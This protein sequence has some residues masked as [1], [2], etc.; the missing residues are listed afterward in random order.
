MDVLCTGAA[1]FIGSHTVDL[2]V[3]RGHRV[4]ALDSLDP[5]VHG[6]NATPKNLQGHLDRGAIEFIMGDVRDR[7]LMERLVQRADAVLHLAA[8]V[9]IGQ[10]MYMP[11]HYADVNVGGTALLLE[12]LTD[13]A[14]RRVQRLVVASSMSLYGEGQG[15]CPT[16]GPVVPADRTDENLARGRFELF[17]GRCGAQVEPIATPEDKPL[18]CTSIYAITKK[19]QEEM[20]VVFGR[21]YGLPVVALRY[22]NVYGPRQ[23]LNNPYTGVA[24]IFL[25]RLMNGHSP[26]VFEDGG[27]SRDFISVRDIARANVLSLESTGTGQAIYN[28]GTG[29]NTSVLGVAEI[30]RAGLGLSTAIDVTRTYRGGDIR[31]CHADASRLGQALGWKAQVRVEDGFQELIEWSRGQHP[32]DTFDRSLQEL[33]SRGLVS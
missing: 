23:S 28:V 24:A 10:S 20:A 3:E 15:R 13:K 16:C 4:V 7:A 11:H 2:L 21:A 17:C 12:L 22:F 32:V 8:A 33:R 1:G 18:S 6:E 26:V 30:L 29:R 5:Q 19:V 27:Q 9:G 14:K 25:S 31:H